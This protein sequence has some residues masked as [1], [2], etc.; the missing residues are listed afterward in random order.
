MADIQ[1]FREYTSTPLRR[2]SF[3]CFSTKRFTQDVA[4][5]F[6]LVE[7]Y[8]KD[9]RKRQANF[10]TDWFINGNIPE[11]LQER[12]FLS[13][14]NIASE[15]TR[16]YSAKANSA[17]DA[18]GLTFKDK[19]KNHGGGLGGIF[20]ALRQ[21]TGNNKLSIDLFDE[22]QLRTVEM[23][24]ENGFHDGEGNLIFRPDHTY[25]PFGGF[26]GKLPKFRMA[27]K[28]AGFDANALGIY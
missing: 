18:V 2:N 19:A 14:M 13:K 27:L 8:R 11:D 24:N 20:G 10:I 25:M 17:I 6:L 22:V 7:G 28:E 12:G 4:I 23:L 9:R 3:Y 15:L 26:A 16:E 21:K 5:V 1:D